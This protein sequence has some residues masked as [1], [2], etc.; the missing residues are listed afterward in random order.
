MTK[1]NSYAHNE[2]KHISKDT[3][4]DHINNLRDPLGRGDSTVFS[5]YEKLE[6]LP[7]YVQTNISKFKKY[8]H[9]LK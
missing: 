4:E 3:M 5:H 8:L 6:E 1:I 2:F 9:Q 7:I